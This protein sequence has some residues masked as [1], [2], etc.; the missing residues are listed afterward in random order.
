MQIMKIGE[1]KLVHFSPHSESMP[2]V[3][4]PC[5]C[6]AGDPAG[7]SAGSSAKGSAGGSEAEGGTWAYA[8]ASALEL[9]AGEA[10][11]TFLA[12]LTMMIASTT[13]K[14]PSPC[15]RHP[16]LPRV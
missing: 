8:E 10:G 2:A 3:S 14:E 4:P 13:G 9:R 5:M 6:P 11:P 12:V 15:P 7:G 1:V 16:Y